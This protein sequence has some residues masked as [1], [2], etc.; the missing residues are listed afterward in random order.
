MVHTLIWDKKKSQINEYSDINTI[1]KIWG[2]YWSV[3]SY[4]QPWAWHF[5]VLKLCTNAWW[6]AKVTKIRQWHISITQVWGHIILNH[7]KGCSLSFLVLRTHSKI[8]VLASVPSIVKWHLVVT[9]LRT[10]LSPIYQDSTWRLLGQK[11]SHQAHN[12]V[13]LYREHANYAM[14]LHNIV[15]SKGCNNL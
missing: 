4:L 10:K 1:C 8:K 14:P 13:H 12:H 3:T 7:V 5:F 9:H 6:P 11:G 15:A 2:V